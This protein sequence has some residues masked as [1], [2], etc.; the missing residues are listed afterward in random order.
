MPDTR[1]RLLRTSARGAPR[2]TGGLVAILAGGLLLT[3]AAAD[4]A[5]WTGTSAS[6]GMTAT[7]EGAQLT[8]S[9]GARFSST[10]M[11]SVQ[12]RAV[13]VACAAGAQDLI[14]LIDERSPV[15]SGT[16][17]FSLVGG[18]VLWSPGATTLSYTLPRDISER[19]DGCLVGHDA[20][21]AAGF[22]FNPLA[23]GV[24]DDGLGLQRLTLAHGAAKS[25]ARARTN[26]RFP[27]PR[28]LARRIA[29]AEP[30]M[31][32][33]FAPTIRRARRNGVVHVVGSETSFKRVQLSYRDNDGQPTVLEGRRR[34]EP[35]IQEPESDVPV[36]ESDR[37][38][39]RRRAAHE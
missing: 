26:R 38:E 39:R 20:D 34:G 24:V 22:G 29:A 31:R 37:S 7:L 36:P 1:R 10:F 32:V 27:S 33:A 9:P 28:A 13:T 21:V 3:S 5:T 12:G 4:A 14:E 25:I 30:Q 35:D 18:P 19:A 23:T 6:T 8:V 2:R 11:R 17:D 15:P 16:F